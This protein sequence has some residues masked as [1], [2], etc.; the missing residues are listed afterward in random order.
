MIY[1]FQS[2]PIRLPWER[3]LHI[4]NPYG[5]HPYMVDMRPQVTE[6][7]R[8]PDAIV[9]SNRFPYTA[10]I[11]HGWFENTPI[12]SKWVRVVV[13]F[14]DN[15]DAFVLTAYAESEVIDGEVIWRKENG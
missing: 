7:L 4:I 15:D 10:R 9:R 6:T 8:N 2:Q 1:D 13:N 3:W 12:G 14:V 5:D 11:Y